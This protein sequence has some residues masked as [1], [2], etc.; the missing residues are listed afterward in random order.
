MSRPVEVVVVAGLML[1]YLA[2]LALLATSTIH[3]LVA[4]AAVMALSKVVTAVV[5][6]RGVTQRRRTVRDPRRFD[7]FTDAEWKHR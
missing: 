6:K 3:G 4:Y 2:S 5:R 7:R 1:G